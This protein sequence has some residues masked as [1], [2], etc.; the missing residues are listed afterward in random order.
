MTN[1][2]LAKSFP[3]TFEDWE[4]RART[5][6]PVSSFDYITGGAG[7]EE[8]MR[9]N[10]TVFLR[11]HIQPRVLSDVSKRDLTVTLFGRTF[12]APFLLAPLGIQGVTHPEAELGSARA[13]SRLGIPFILSTVASRTIEQV[14]YVMGGAPRWFQLFWPTDNDVMVSLVRRAE[15]AGYSAIVLT[16]DTAAGFGWRP[17]SIRNHFYPFLFGEGMANFISDPVFRSK[18]KQPPEKDMYAAIMQFLKI[19]WNPALSWE[20]LTFLRKLTKLPILLKGILNPNDAEL[21]LQL[22]MDGIVV[23][24]HGGRQLD[25]EIAALEALPMICDCIQGRIPVLMDSG[26]RGGADVLKTIALGATAVLIG[27]PY[28]Y[29]LAVA[30]E[31][32]VHQVIR[33][34]IADIDISLANTGRKSIAEID[35]SLLVQA[36]I[37]N[38]I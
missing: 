29:G 15:K 22:G 7:S 3:V 28:I 11:W 21:A 13:A 1:E 9:A 26:I 38:K 12:P 37:G 8:T 6:L 20:N 32:G 14:A 34:L 27:R 18:L 16:V 2:D 31:K 5:I 4:N 25:G 17:R 33:N 23:S 10:R 30:G 36:Q 24:N 35:R 19:I